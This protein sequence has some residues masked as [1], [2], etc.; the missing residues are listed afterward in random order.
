MGDAVCVCVSLSLSPRFKFKKLSLGSFLANSL[1][2]PIEALLRASPQLLLLGVDEAR[3]ERR[4]ADALRG[5]SKAQAS[6]QASLGLAPPRAE[7]R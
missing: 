4:V 5:A 1:G 2:R 6:V 7:L 3:R